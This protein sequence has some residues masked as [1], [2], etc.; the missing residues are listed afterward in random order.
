M[1]ALARWHYARRARKHR[2]WLLRTGRAE[3]V[4]PTRNVGAAA[5]RAHLERAA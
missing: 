5:V 3:L 4:R 2:A 1:T